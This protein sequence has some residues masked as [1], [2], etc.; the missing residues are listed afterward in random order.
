MEF[1]GDSNEQAAFDVLV[2]VREAVQR[3]EQL[4]PVIMEKLLENFHTIK[5]VKWVTRLCHWNIPCITI[6]SECLT[7]ETTWMREVFQP[8]WLH[9][10]CVGMLNKL[11][12][13][14]WAECKTSSQHVWVSCCFICLFCAFFTRSRLYNIFTLACFHVRDT[15]A[16][17]VI[18]VLHLNISVQCFAL[19]NLLLCV[20][21]RI[22]RHALWIMGEYANSKQDILDVTEEIKKG[23]G[24]VRS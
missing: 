13:S 21:H 11:G 1:L 2:F 4:K 23:L 16:W 6:L 9:V 5:T 10:R 20:Y 14:L 24:D 3:F 18:F 7:N 15:K 8:R 17:K 19:S 12:S 22:H